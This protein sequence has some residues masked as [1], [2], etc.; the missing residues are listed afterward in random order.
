[1]PYGK[2]PYGQNLYG[3]ISYNP[4]LIWVIE[5]DWDGDGYY[6]GYNEADR[7]VDINIRRGRELPVETGKG[8]EHSI[9]G[10]ARITLTNHDDRYN[11]YNTSSPY[12]PNVRQ[13]KYIRIGVMNGATSSVKY[14]FS[15]TITDID[16]QKQEKSG[17]YAVLS[18]KDGW[19]F[20][21]NKNTNIA[22]GT[23]YTTGTAMAAILSDVEWPSIWGSSLDT[24]VDS[25]NYFY[26]TNKSARTALEELNDSEFG[27]MRIAGDGTF[28]FYERGHE[29]AAD[30][31][32]TQDDLLKDI[33][34]PAPWK[35]TRNKAIVNVYPRILREDETIFEINNIPS[36]D[37][38]EDLIVWGDLSYDG[39][40]VASNS[41]SQPVT[42]N[43]YQNKTTIAFVAATKKITDSANGLAG[44]TTGMKIF[45]SG[46]QKPSNNGTF[47]VVTGG[48]AGEIVVSETLIDESAGSNIT[49]DQ[50][51]SCY[52]ANAESGGGGAD[53]SAY[54]SVSAEL[55]GERVK[56]TFYN[57][58]PTDPFYLTFYRIVGDAID[59]PNP[60]T[61]E[62]TATGVS[63]IIPFELDVPWLEVQKYASNYAAF[64]VEYL[65]ASDPFPIVNLQ[66]RPEYQFSVDLFDKIG[67]S[68]EKYGIDASDYKVGKIEHGWNIDTGQSV[69]TKWYTEKR[70]AAA[71]GGDTMVNGD[72]ETGD[73]SNWTTAG[74]T[75]ISVVDTDKSEGT[76]AMFCDTLSG[77][78]G[79]TSDRVAAL[80]GQTYKITLST[81]ETFT[82]P[83]LHT[84]QCAVTAVTY[85]DSQN[86]DTNFVNSN[87]VG[88]YTGGSAYRA[89]YK[90]DCS[91]IPTGAVIKT[92]LL[93]N[94]LTS[95]YSQ[96]NT[97]ITLYRTTEAWTAASVTWNTKPV[98]EPTGIGSLTLA[99]AEATGLK[100]VTL[101][102]AYMNELLST[103]TDTGFM[104]VASPEGGTVETTHTVY[105]REYYIAGYNSWKDHQTGI[106]RYYP[107]YAYRIRSR[108]Y[109]TS[110]TTSN[111][112]TFSAAPYLTITY[113]TIAYP[114]PHY[115]VYIKWY[116]DPSAGD[117]IRTD[118]VCRENQQSAWNVRSIQL[119]APAT[120]ESYEIVIDA[121][122][123]DATFYV[124]DIQVVPLGYY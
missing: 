2:F 59:C 43:V 78:A 48:V 71:S 42:R 20:L 12:Y 6:D 49:I 103:W 21:E 84:T 118:V 25:L 4:N 38:G 114:Y 85:I 67:L 57:L 111:K 11:I 91:S 28:E 80:A 45:V 109:T 97:N 18:C 77:T 65:N 87:I 112:N 61:A 101:A 82:Q 66:D 117:L 23:T 83:D 90:F 52:T 9:T 124:D 40:G 88:G 27:T 50:A 32:L 44:F 102:P 34:L 41:I 115:T 81:K 120:A 36:L 10:E 1:M 8:F 72:F 68:I 98:H 93:K 58:H 54:V 113:D 108:T 89:L 19:Y 7:C 86:P 69:T 94:T 47:T 74:A 95:V 26:A 60:S 63:E 39:R 53:M 123:S 119:N 105:W 17:E 107:V 99:A 110:T 15:G 29:P 100:T 104:L 30:V 62:E 14:L 3:E 37:A 92:S 73:L 55:F 31:S 22:V 122:Q 5:V 70:A 35:T 64:L 96:I 13:G 76:Y 33:A 16:I 46:A 106:T 51:I 75:V 116:D 24:G 56:N 121:T 79:I